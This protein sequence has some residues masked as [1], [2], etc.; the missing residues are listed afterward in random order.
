MPTSASMSGST[1]STRVI[2][3]VLYWSLDA[4]RIY[5]TRMATD[6]S[7]LINRRGFWRTQRQRKFGFK[8][9]TEYDVW[10]MLQDR[11]VEREVEKCRKSRIR[12]TRWPGKRT[13]FRRHRAIQ[14]SWQCAAAAKVEE[15]TRNRVV[16]TPRR[17]SYF[18]QS[19]SCQGQQTKMGRD[20][21]LEKSC[22]GDEQYRHET[23][24]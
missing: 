3:T 19:W 12:S 4:S 15:P 22:R 13:R 21:K 9:H 2:R 8:K 11:E 14:G 10:G 7:C 16:D 17:G 5:D 6:S 23:V 1:Y 18:R 24:T 20:G